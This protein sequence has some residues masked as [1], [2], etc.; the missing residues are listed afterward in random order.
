M[1]AHQQLLLLQHPNTNIIPSDEDYFSSQPPLPPS[2]DIDCIPQPLTKVPPTET[3][4]A[5]LH[6]NSIELLTI[7]TLNLVHRE[8]TNLPP[9]PT[10][11]TPTPCDNWTQFES[12][13]LHRIFVC[14]QLR[15]QNHLT[16]AT[17]ASLVNLGL[18]LSTIGSFATISNPPKGKTIKK[19]RQCLDKV[20]LNIVF[21]ECIALGGNRYALL[22]V[23][24]ATRYYWIYRMS[25][26]SS[27]SITSALEQLKSDAGCLPYRFHSDSDRKLIGGYSL[28]WILLNSSNVI[29]ATTGRQSSNGLA[30]CTWRTLIQMAR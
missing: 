28:R 30:K 16:A 17:N 4:Y 22:L 3:S 21:G 8:A 7:R 14:R 6:K 1:A 15:N 25:S 2:I 9:I 19:R 13:N 29:A 24:F 18:I 27:T 20:S 5:T 23:D 10:S 12:L 11:L 26:L